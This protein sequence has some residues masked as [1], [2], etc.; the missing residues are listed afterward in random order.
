I[1]RDTL[2]RFLRQEQLDRGYLLVV[3]PH[4]GKIDLY[5]K[6]GHW[7]KYRDSIFPPMVEPGSNPDLDAPDSET[8]ILRPMNCPHH[9]EIY[10]S[11][12][13]SYR[14]LPLRLAEFAT[15]Y[16]YEQSGELNG[17]L[18]TRGF[19]Q[20]D[21]HMFMMP[22]QLEDEFVKVVELVLIV[23][24]PLGLNDFKARLRVR[25]PASSKYV[26]SDQAWEQAESAILSAV[27]KLGLPYTVEQGESGF[28]GPKLDFVFPDA[29]NR[30][31]Q[32]ATA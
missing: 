6:S 1:L 5:K 10:K 18:R 32:L 23:C 27:K 26:G 14:D 12:M 31:W 7:Y 8:Y 20:D 15:V 3:T 13:R 28:Y 4:I 30:D 21:S 2:E 24:R 22:E 11:E 9:I 19:T 17:L 25:D 16:R 29:L